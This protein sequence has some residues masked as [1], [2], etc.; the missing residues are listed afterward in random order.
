[1]ARKKVETKTESMKTQARRKNPELW[2]KY[3]LNKR[4]RLFLGGNEA[5]AKKFQ[6]FHSNQR[7][8]MRPFFSFNV[9]QM[10]NRTA[11][12]GRK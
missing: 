2:N 6:R 4:R 11:K 8:S 7:F 10:K 3:V 9:L 1:M 5:K 12:E